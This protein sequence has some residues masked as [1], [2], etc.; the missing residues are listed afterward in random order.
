M[1]RYYSGDPLKDF[2]NWDE[3]A[4]IWL[5]KRPTCYCCAEHIQ[6]EYGYRVDGRLYCK[7]CLDGMKEWLED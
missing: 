6:D 2:D 5:N 7:R 3:D 4:E 1:S